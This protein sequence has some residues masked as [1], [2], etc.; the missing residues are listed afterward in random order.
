MEI[1]RLRNKRLGAINRTT[2]YRRENGLSACN[3]RTYIEGLRPAVSP[4]INRRAINSAG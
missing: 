2:I 3:M 4:A 1:S